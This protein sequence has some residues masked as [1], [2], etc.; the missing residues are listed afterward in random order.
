MRV[1]IQ[2]YLIINKD[3]NLSFFTHSCPAGSTLGS[4]TFTIVGRN[5]M[6]K[7]ET[8]TVCCKNKFNHFHI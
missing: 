8:E 4:D 7:T 2:F 6:T 3:F 5:G 1:I